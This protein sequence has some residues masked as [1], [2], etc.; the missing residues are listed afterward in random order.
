MEEM[1]PVTPTPAV[2]CAN[3]RFWVINPESTGSCV[4]RCPT[5]D[6]NCNPCWPVTGWKMFC[7]EH[8]PA[9]RIDVEARKVII[10]EVNKPKTKEAANGTKA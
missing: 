8:E 9:G 6:L 4:R 5:R 7:G 10:L 1:T 2:I 3:C